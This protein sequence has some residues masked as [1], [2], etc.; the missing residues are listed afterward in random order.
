[1]VDSNVVSNIPISG[2]ALKE[3]FADILITASQKRKLNLQNYRERI[4]RANEEQTQL[5]Q[6]ALEWEVE[7]ENS[8]S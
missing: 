8:A 6:G 4:Y 3:I 5:I 2:R 7:G 1:M